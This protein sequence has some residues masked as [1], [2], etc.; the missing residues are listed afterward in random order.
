M[1]QGSESVYVCVCACVCQCVG[2][3]VCVLV[4]RLAVCGTRVAPSAP[5]PGTCVCLAPPPVALP[6]VCVSLRVFCV[7]GRPALRPAQRPQ[8]PLRRCSC[9]ES[10]A[11]GR[12]RSLVLEVPRAGR[13]HRRRRC[14]CAVVP[15]RQLDPRRASTFPKHR[16]R[17]TGKMWVCME[18]VGG[19]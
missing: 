12:R 7:V 10:P 13:R 14:Y 6:P 16:G 19:C 1:R 11:V 3:R 15:S 8:W 17:K 18:P 5:L 2:V 4:C 9:R